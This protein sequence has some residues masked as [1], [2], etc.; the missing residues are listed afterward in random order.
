MK[1]YGDRELGQPWLRWWLAAWRHQA[2]TWT[3]VDLSSAMSCGFHV[4]AIQQEMPQSSIPK[5]CLKIT[6]LK[7]H[8][9]FP[10]TNEL[11]EICILVSRNE[12]VVTYTMVPMGCKYQCWINIFRQHE[13]MVHSTEIML[14]ENWK[15]LKWQASRGRNTKAVAHHGRLTIKLVWN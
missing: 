7:F 14:R 3:N 11:I 13:S 1:P 15:V 8:S 4:R 2:I 12:D 9:N 6:C 5:I 10:W